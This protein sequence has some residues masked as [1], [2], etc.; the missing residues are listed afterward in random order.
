MGFC[1]RAHNC[2]HITVLEDFGVI[3]DGAIPAIAFVRWEGD[4][5]SNAVLAFDVFM[6]DDLE[7]AGHFFRFG[8]VNLFDVGM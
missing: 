2:Q 1:I 8:S 7:N 3:E 4:Q 6:G 5:T